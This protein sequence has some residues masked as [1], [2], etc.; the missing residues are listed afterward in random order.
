MTT[1]DVIYRLKM[2]Q[3][4]LFRPALSA[5]FG[6]SYFTILGFLRVCLRISHEMSVRTKQKG[7]SRRLVLVLVLVHAVI[8]HLDDTRVEIERREPHWRIDCRCEFGA[9]VIAGV[10]AFGGAYTGAFGCAIALEGRVRQA[11]PEPVALYAV[12]VQAAE[13]AAPMATA[14]PEGSN[15]LT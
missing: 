12:A 4:Q 15:A 7:F 9:L 10:F 14:L 6:A 2:F 3:A 1:D 11:A 8:A 13:G 5:S